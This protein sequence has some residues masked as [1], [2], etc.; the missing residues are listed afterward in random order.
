MKEEG[1]VARRTEG[2]ERREHPQWRYTE[3][4]TE[5]NAA[6]STQGEKVVVN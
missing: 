1:G 3:K 6:S 4:I 2:E 5:G